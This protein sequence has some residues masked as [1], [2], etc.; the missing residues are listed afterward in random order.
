[1][2]APLGLNAANYTDESLEKAAHPQEI[3]KSDDV[4][5]HLDYLHSGLGSNSCGEEQQEAYKVKRQNFSMAFRMKIVDKGQE[6]AE[7]EKKYLD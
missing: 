5:L 7:A 1:M 3:E 4:I 6:E 2:E